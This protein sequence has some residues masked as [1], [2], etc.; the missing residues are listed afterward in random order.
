MPCPPVS[1]FWHFLYT[2]ISL[3]GSTSLITFPICL[4]HWWSPSDT[5]SL[6][7]ALIHTHLCLNHLRV[8]CYP[9][10]ASTQSTSLAVT[11]TQ[12]FQTHPYHMC[13]PSQSTSRFPY[14]TPALAPLAITPTLNLTYPNYLSILSTR[15]TYH[16][17]RKDDFYL[18]ISF[19][20]LGYH[21]SGKCYHGVSSGWVGAVYWW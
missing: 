10:S 13:T 12:T 16:C 20:Y 5:V 4:F 11:H 1:L 6:I 3:S 17:Y 2:F 18:T 8:I 7:L 14:S 21:F 9:Y 15:D 19:L